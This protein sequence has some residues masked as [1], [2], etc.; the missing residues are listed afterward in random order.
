MKTDDRLVFAKDVIEKLEKQVFS[1]RLK[2]DE[3]LSPMGI[4]YK[5]VPYGHRQDI[6]GDCSDWDVFKAGSAWGEPDGHVLF[7]FSVKVPETMRGKEVFLFVT[8]G[9]DDIWNTDNPQ[10]LVYVNGVRRSG[11]DMNHYSISIFSKED[12]ELDSES[13]REVEIG[14]YSYSNLS[15]NGNLLNLE[16]AAL[17]E[18]AKDAFFDLKVPY[19]AARAMLGIENRKNAIDLLSDRKALE[20]IEPIDEKNAEIITEYLY[21]ACKILTMEEP[22]A[23]TKASEYLH[24]NL[25]GTGEC[26]ATV[27]SVGHTHIDVAWKWPVKQ[28]REKVIRSYST[29]LEL[30]KRYPEYLFVASTPQMYEF[31]REDE[32]E[33]YEEIR[34]K[35]KEKRF[36]AEGAMWLEADCN[37]TG[38]ESLVRQILYGKRYMKEKF[39]TDSFVLWLPDVFGY[40]AA[41]PQ[42]LKKSGVKV[43]VTTKL[44]WNDTNRLPH[45]L[46][47]WRGID[48]SEVATY[49]ITTCDFPMAHR[50]NVDGGILNYTYNGRQD[51]SQVMGTWEAF[52]EKDYT[53]EA[54]TCYGFGDGGGGP[55]FEMLEMDRRLRLGLPGVPRTVQKSVSGFFNDLFKNLDA[56]NK[57][58]SLPKWSDELYLEFHRGT[59]TS[60][61]RNKRYNRQLE[62][63]LKEAEL[64]AT[65][66][67]LTGSSDSYPREEL[68]GIWKVLMLNQFHDILPGSS[69]E[70]VYVDSAKE[71]DEAI[72]KTKSLI[73][74]CKEIIGKN[75]TS[76]PAV[77]C[78]AFEAKDLPGSG[79]IT[80]L[81]KPDG[82][83][84]IVTPYLMMAIDSNGEI[85][86]LYD[87]MAGRE[88]RVD[89]AEPLNRLIAFEDK[90]KEYDC[91]NIDADFENV[92]WDITDVRKLEFVAFDDGGN[93]IGS[94][95]EGGSNSDIRRVEVNI[96]RQF[97]SSV[98]NQTIVIRADSRRIDFKTT[99]DWHE[100]QILLKAAFPVDIDS[101]RICC[102]IQYGSLFR[103]LTR[104]N[105]WDR[106]KFE[107]CAH[108]WMDISEEDYGVAVLNDCKYGYDAKEKLMRLTLIKSGIFPNPNADQGKHVFTYSLFPHKG[109]HIAGKVIEE[110]DKLNKEAHYHEKAAFVAALEKSVMDL[111]GEKGVFVEA[112]K[113]AEDSDNVII[114]LREGYGISHS[115]KAK[116]FGNL[117][118]SVTSVSECDLMEN[119]IDSD[120][121]EFNA[122]KKEI[123]FEI[124]PFEIKTFVVE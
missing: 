36:E 11:M 43:F 114:R 123:A 73:T 111:Q 107:C 118:V 27:A 31:A 53:D 51:A 121:I 14:L 59:Y 96:E 87:R 35:I 22:Y 84:D 44:G 88:L 77:N 105:S 8:T 61:G 39:G 70:E 5:K 9:A 56:G 78:D 97:K 57:W 55:T 20:T 29:V 54:L 81:R 120:S 79:S 64:V 94:F 32:P 86:S 99:A 1:P 37:L 41:L 42:I 33:L 67:A 24:D 17:N 122:E 104:N 30:M 48:G 7:K 108:R 46:F 62:H 69:I 3:V 102:E 58:D 103:K 75:W 98:I 23:F 65:I 52:R 119:V 83:T 76:H 89:G 26:P 110:A 71:Y 34:E 40:S 112:V 60:M 72:E 80:G 68:L 15:E 47:M 16:L 95:G 115:V 50:A 49:M 66:A 74:R 101:D 38:G 100:H 124:G 12:W 45:D 25:Y 82:T 113:L 117:G 28:T 13:K 2:S 10:M 19:D 18:E 93:I 109:D 21:K 4:R 6:L 91:W 92:S 106:A 116:I 90:P 85:T 63:L